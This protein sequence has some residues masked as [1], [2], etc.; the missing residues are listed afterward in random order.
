[1]EI[2]EHNTLQLFVMNEILN[3]VTLDTVCCREFLKSWLGRDD[4]GN[5]I[6]FIFCGIDADI[7]N[8]AVRAIDGLK[9]Y[10]R[11]KLVS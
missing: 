3:S 8:N 9:L 2:L 4:D 6:M 11:F 5:R 1:M 10:K 7:G